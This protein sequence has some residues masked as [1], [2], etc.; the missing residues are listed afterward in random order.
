LS[1]SAY[2]Y[3]A[4]TPEG[5]VV[6]GVLEAPSERGA[7][8]DLRRQHLV[9]VDVAPVGDSGSA[10]ASPRRA[11]RGRTPSRPAALALFT[12]TLGTL[13]SAGV[14]L[15][16]A[17]SFAAAQARH[18]QVAHAASSVHEAVRTGASLSEALGRHPEVFS[19]FFVAMVAAGEESGRL[20][21]TLA[22]LATHMDEEVELR[23]QVRAALVYPALMGVVSGA[24][25]VVLLLLVIPRFAAILESEGGVLPLSTR[26]LLAVSGFLT[27]A[28]WL[29]LIA[30]ALAALAVRAWGASAENLRRW[31]RWRLSLPMVGDLE[32][33]FATARFTRALGMLLGSGRPMLPS[34]RGAGA[35]V[36]NL[37]MSASLDGAIE[38]VS[39]GERLQGALSVALPP[40]AVEMLGVGEESGT[41]AQL[42]LRVADAYDAE[43]R[44]TLRT[45]VGII[46]PALILFFG[47]VV[48]FIA[49][50]MLQ[51]IYGIRASGL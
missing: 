25:V 12:R 41:L 44:R 48:G 40:L 8:E 10:A 5:R 11:A 2:R 28:W 21:E 51:A 30:A 3:R 13:T 38:R 43:L 29:L 49:L 39:H 36:T 32:H 37:E 9:P 45:L 7:I 23:G 19:A 1:V 26:V 17:L 46:E 4:A 6:E 50:A 16:R 22:R 18:P 14:P 24:G 31:H 35:T 27:S 20:D 33:D 34:L 47:A 42:C 15:D